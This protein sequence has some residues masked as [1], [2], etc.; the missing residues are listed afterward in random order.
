MATTEIFPGT[1]VNDRGK[2]FAWTGRPG[3]ES[4]Q[5]RAEVEKK[6]RQLTSVESALIK[7]LSAAGIPL[8]AAQ[9]LSLVILEL[10]GAVATQSE[11]FAFLQQRLNELA[12]T[13][14]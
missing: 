9:E 13:N 11:Q 12:G 8:D 5:S 3:I 14:V 2:A 7:R 4:G 10:R 1:P 6:T